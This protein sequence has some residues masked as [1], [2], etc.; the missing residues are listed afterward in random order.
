MLMFAKDEEAAGRVKRTLTANP[1]NRTARFVD[2]AVSQTGL[3]R[4]WS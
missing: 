1:P 3:Q 4:T 2:F